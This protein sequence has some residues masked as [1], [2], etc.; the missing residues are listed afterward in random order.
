MKTIELIKTLILMDKNC[1][2]MA[3]F[4]LIGCFGGKYSELI[5]RLD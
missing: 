4:S 3:G 2:K 5:K 1:G